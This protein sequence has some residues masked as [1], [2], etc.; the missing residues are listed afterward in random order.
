MNLHVYFWESKQIK[1]QTKFKFKAHYALIS[2]SKKQV[3][4]RTWMGNSPKSDKFQHK[5]TQLQ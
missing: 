5:K 3:N 4:R 2:L 1:P